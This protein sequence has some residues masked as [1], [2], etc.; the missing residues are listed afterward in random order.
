MYNHTIV[1]SNKQH[2]KHIQHME[3][4]KS[5]INFQTKVV[6]HELM[7][8]IGQMHE[9]QRSDRD[10]YIEIL[11]D[12]VPADQRRNFDKEDTLD[13]TPYDVESILQYPLTVCVQ[14]IVIT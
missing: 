14:Q 7:H 10:N 2:A 9:Q 6:I 5:A 12:N 1:C 11:Y 3:D 13:R 4:A 8:A